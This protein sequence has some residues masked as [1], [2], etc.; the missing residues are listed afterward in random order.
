MKSDAGNKFPMSQL[1]ARRTVGEKSLTRRCTPDGLKP[2]VDY[3]NK[4][5]LDLKVVHSYG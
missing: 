2:H 4:E 1:L 3:K 5:T